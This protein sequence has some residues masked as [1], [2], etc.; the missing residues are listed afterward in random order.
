MF[1]QKVS[2]AKRCRDFQLEKSKINDQFEIQ[3]LNGESS[4]SIR[5]PYH[6]NDLPYRQVSRNEHIFLFAKFLSKL[7]EETNLSL[8]RY[9]LESRNYDAEY[10]SVNSIQWIHL[11]AS[12]LWILKV[13]KFVML[14]KRIGGCCFTQKQSIDCFHWSFLNSLLNFCLSI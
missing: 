10:Y 8:L 9:H 14:V 13:R 2:I 12:K 4:N 5:V 11:K 3:T 6:K 7:S 1:W